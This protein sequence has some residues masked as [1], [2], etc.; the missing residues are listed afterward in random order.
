[1]SLFEWLYS[2]ILSD[3]PTTKD[4]ERVV[5]SSSAARASRKEPRK[6]TQTDAVATFDKEDI[7]S[8]KEADSSSRPEGT[9]AEDVRG[10]SMTEPRRP[11]LQP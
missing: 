11:E 3:R 2:L 6:A 4:D 8:A 10:P 5:E 9:E 7:S 1:M